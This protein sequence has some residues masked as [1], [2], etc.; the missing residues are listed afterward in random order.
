MDKPKKQFTLLCSM[1]ALFYVTKFFGVIPFGLG[2]Y[3]KKK[4]L[5][6]SII[7]NIWVVIV[8]SLS[9]IS[10]HYE[11]SSLNAGDTDGSGK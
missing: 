7:G 11:T 9:C 3:Y 5:K 6:L 8:T 2:A 1:S 4:I 10:S